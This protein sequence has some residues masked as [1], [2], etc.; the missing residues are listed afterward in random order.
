MRGTR[1]AL[2][3]GLAISCAALAAAGCGSG[4]GDTTTGPNNGSAIVSLGDSVAS[5]EGNPSRS[6]PRW[7]N[8]ACHRS[9]IAGQTIAAQKAQQ[10]NPD[11]GFFDYACS[12]AS[13]Q[14]GLLGPY[15]GIEPAPL[16]PAR[17]QID[18]LR[19]T[20]AI[21]Q[22]GGGLA[23]VL[24]SIGAN[25]V[26]F[27]KAFKFC[28]LVRRC[29]EKHF[30][31][32]FPY[33]A[34]SS[35]FPTLETSVSQGLAELPERFAQLSSALDDVGVPASRVI[36]VDYFDP[37]TGANGADCTMLFGGVTADESRWAQQHVLLPLNAQIDAAA[38]E[39]GWNAVTGVAE[40]FRGHGL[41]A[42][43]AQRWVVTLGEGLGGE[44]LPLGGGAGF[45]AIRDAIESTASTLHPNAEG[46]RQIADLIDPV[47]TRVL[48][49]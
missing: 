32:A 4:G 28:T 38:K 19:D 23:A 17:S 9:P 43:Q 27:S 18:Q 48:N 46:Q 12:G 8:R 36:L 29:W 31:P 3:A 16:Q 41:C 30:N 21:T 5:G 20:V 42:P 37:T 47:L 13:I 39:H 44:R 26:G 2:I 6:G 40:R 11:L 1:G 15:K 24:I 35:R 22:T 7:E 34:A 25:D 10:S 33:A 49:Q 45:L 14:K